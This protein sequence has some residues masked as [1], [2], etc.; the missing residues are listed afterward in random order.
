MNSI[1]P[2]LRGK[3]IVCEGA[4]GAGKSTGAAYLAAQLTALGIPTLL[5]REVG[6][7]PIG[8]QLRQLAFTAHPE[9]VLDPIARLLMVYA[10]RIQNLKRIVEP[11]LAAGT[12][13]VCDRFADS[14]FVYQGQADGLNYL[15]QDFEKIEEVKYLA[16][17]PDHLLFF[18]ITAETSIV[19]R[20][21]RGAVDNVHYKGDLGKTQKVVEHYQRRMKN[22][23]LR[24]SQPIHR[25]DAEKPPE[26]VNAHLRLVAQSLLRELKARQ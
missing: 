6:S 2:A 17:R 5:T 11:A 13:V 19:R 4:D 15:I 12:Y 23:E 26:A 16:H 21:A 24:H 22:M 14:T 9:E 3:F 20:I 8:Q 10:A 7:T 25:I 18:D 1:T